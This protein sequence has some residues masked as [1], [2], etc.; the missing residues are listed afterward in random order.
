[1]LGACPEMTMSM[2][3]TTAALPASREAE[4][5][6]LRMTWRRLAGR[7]SAFAAARAREWE[8]HQAIAE[9]QRM[10]DRA[11]ADMGLTRGEIEFVVRRNAS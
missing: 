1:M 6:R 5:G 9:L 11:L 4:I 7:V 10:D 2:Q 3:S 8:R